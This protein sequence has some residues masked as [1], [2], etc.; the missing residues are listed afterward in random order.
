M[1]S[2][3][4]TDWHSTNT[5]SRRNYVMW[6]HKYHFSRFIFLMERFNLRNIHAKLNWINARIRWKYDL[7][8]KK[9]VNLPFNNFGNM[10]TWAE[11]YFS[12]MTNMKIWTIRFFL[13]LATTTPKKWHLEYIGSARFSVTIVNCYKEKK[14]RSFEILRSL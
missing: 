9:S 8:N 14:I 7:L 4:F 12:F 6:K 3:F 2:E 11:V 1:R 10:S 13:S 5:H